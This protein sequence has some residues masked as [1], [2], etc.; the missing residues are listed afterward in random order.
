MLDIKLLRKDKAQI[1]KRL[2]T[3]E[4]DIDLSPILAL[5]ERI[6]ENKMKVEELK[7]TRNHLS[8][9]IGEKKRKKEDAAELMQ[10]V[11]G[12]GD[13]ISALDH[14]LAHLEPELTDKLGRLPNLPRED[15]KV[16]PDPKDNVCIKTFGEKK[17]F[18][19]P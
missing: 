15:S 1:E 2:K 4:P 16:S 18:H 6:R 3:K 9:E 17:E 13:T 8:K 14:E 11:S 12:L 19:F 7:S 5:D 10:Q